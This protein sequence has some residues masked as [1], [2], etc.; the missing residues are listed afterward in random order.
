MFVFYCMYMFLSLL[1]RP[2]ARQSQLLDTQLF[3]AFTCRTHAARKTSNSLII[4][5]L[6][7]PRH[8][9]KS[10]PH[11]AGEQFMELREGLG[12]AGLVVDRDRAVCAEG[13]DLEGHDH[14]VVVVRSVGSSLQE[15][16]RR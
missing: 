9:I 11:H 2:F 3:S 1:L 10:L 4:N 16:W 5:P 13:C 7:S 15:A 14:A 8:L 12:Y 6:H